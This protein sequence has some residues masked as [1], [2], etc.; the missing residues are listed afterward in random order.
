MHLQEI[1]IKAFNEQNWE[2]DLQIVIQNYGVNEVDVPS[3]K[4]QLLFLPETAKSYVLN[5]RIQLSEMI[6]LFKK[7]DT[8]KRML[9]AEVMK[10]VKLIVIMP[11]T[12]AVNEKS[13]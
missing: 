12:N 13:F 6:A 4:A 8:I 1:L 3:L 10:L 7:I 11:A 9:V 5:S 2:D